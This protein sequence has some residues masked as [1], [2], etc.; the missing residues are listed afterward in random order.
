M[1][2]SEE[3]KIVDELKPG[4]KRL[5]LK[6]RCSSKNE[7]REIVSR[8]TGETLRVT[9]ALVGDETGSVLLTLW[10][11]DIDKMQPDRVYRLSNAY[12]TVFKGSLRLNLGK[13]G[14]MEELDEDTPATVKLDNNLSNK[15]YE[16]ERTFRPKYGGI[17]KLSGYGGK[18]YKMDKGKY[19]GGR[20][21][22]E[23]RERRKR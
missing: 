8:K 10:N 22:G 15:V 17:D 3:F 21:K 4:L 11:D 20:G 1:S 5:N 2:E 13:Y 12:T 7:E 14:S 9:E 23:N 19:R 18:P 16:Q 6:V